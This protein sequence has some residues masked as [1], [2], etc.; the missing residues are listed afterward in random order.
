MKL[1]I[2]GI[3][4]FIG[5]KIA[6][7]AIEKGY[8]VVGVD[9]LSQG[10]LNNIPSKAKFIQLDLVKPESINQLPKDVSYILHLAG[11][12]SGE[13]SFDNPVL[14]LEKNTVATLNLIKFGIQ[15]KI[16]RILYASSM[17]V[18]GPVEDAPIDESF[19]CAPLSCYG[20][21]KLAAENYLK[22]YENQLP[23]T[24]FRM[25]NVY[26]PGQD[27][28]NLR[29]GM[30]SI[31]LAH[32]L[33]NNHIPIK[34]SLQRYRDF[35]YIDDVVNIW[36]NALERH[37]TKNE[38]FNLGT[39]VKT[40]ILDLLKKIETILPGFT[41]QEV[42]HTLGDQFGIYADTTKIKKFFN[43]YDFISLDE[44]LLKFVEWLKKN[45]PL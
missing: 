24:I 11:Q 37:D 22:V 43:K 36:L 30:V 14:D 28:N 6:S 18:Y 25:F 3:A 10:S 27:M 41:W 2:T 33:K 12:S 1:L 32:I 19:N 39:G 5:S 20:V 8:E 16:E 34:G 26:G 7:A 35:I 42:E 38:C 17:S 44:G 31:Y 21:G 23:Y 45:P 4:G 13:I 40:K 15:H 29:Q 9:D